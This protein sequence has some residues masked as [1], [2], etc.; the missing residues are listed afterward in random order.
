MQMTTLMF[1][2][3]AIVA[4][5]FAQEARVEANVT[6][7]AP[8]ARQV[9]ISGTHADNATERVFLSGDGTKSYRIPR[10]DLVAPTL[11]A[12]VV[13]NVY[14]YTLSNGKDA[15]Q[16]IETAIFLDSTFEQIDGPKGWITHTFGL[17]V[18]F[19]TA[20]KKATPGI[21]PGES[22]TF[23]AVATKGTAPELGRVHVYSRWYL[24]DMTEIG[25]THMDFADYVIANAKTYVEVS[26]L[27]PQ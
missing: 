2:L 1:L 17:S 10:A 18:Q 11:T 19:E 24:I 27:A 5:A 21:A 20:D 22:I 25:K 7:D 13:G 14:T 16:P 26:A 8:E 3:T 12:S 4:T 23:T 15:K 6:F 9:Q